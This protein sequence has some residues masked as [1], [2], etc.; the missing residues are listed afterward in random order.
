MKYVLM[1]R[2]SETMIHLLK[3][4]IGAG[5]LAMP[6]AV[7]RLGIIASIL[8]LLLIGVFAT[9]CLLLLVRAKL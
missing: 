3:G 1:I 4:S 6:S 5:V 8:G 7:Y 9:Y 2:Y